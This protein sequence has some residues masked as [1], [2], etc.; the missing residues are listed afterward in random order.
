MSE[1]PFEPGH[2]Q[3][4]QGNSRPTF[5]LVTFGGPTLHAG[6]RHLALSPLRAALLGLLATAPD[7]VSTARAIRLL[8]QPAPSRRLRHRISQLIYSLNREFP[9]R[10]VVR[11]HDRQYLSA[12]IA[13]D[14]SDLLAAISDERLA[15][16]AELCKRGFLSELTRSPSDKFSGWLDETR[17]HLLGRIRKAALQQWTRLAGQGRWHQAADAARL[18]VSFNP[19]DERA[20]RM[21]IRAE[22]MSGRVGEAEAAFH[23]FVERSEMGDPEWSPN[24]ATLSLV[25]HLHHMRGQADTKPASRPVDG[26]HSVIGRPEELAALMGALL[27]RPGN[28]LRVVVLRGERGIGK[29]WLAEEAL[30]QGLVTGIRAIRSRARRDRQVSF[31]ETLLDALRSSDLDTE[32]NQLAEPWRGIVKKLLSRSPGGTESSAEPGAAAA[33][34]SNR[35]CLEAVWRLLMEVSRNKPTILFIDDFQWAD[36]D[37]VAGLQYVLERWPSLPLA[38]MLAT[39]TESLRE[40]DS[41]SE[42]LGGSLMRYEP[43]EFSVGALTR[44]A[45]GNLV[46]AVA[47]SRIEAEVRDRIVELSGQNPFFIVQL[48]RQA[49]SG[50]RLPN[51]DPDDFVPVPQSIARVFADRL[52][53]LDDDGER[54]LQLITVLGRPMGVDTLSELSGSSHDSCLQVLDRLQ[55]SRLI[56]WDSRGFVASHEL[57]LHTVYDRMNVARRAWIHGRVAAHLDGVNTSGTSAE[58]AMH[59][60]QA[61]MRA[62]ALRHAMAGA[63]VAEKAGAL[64]EAAKLFALVG[65]DTDDPQIQLG[66]AARVA[67]LH[68]LRRDTVE[69]PACLTEA[70][71]QLRNSQQP[72][73]ALVADL[74]RV[75]LLASKGSRSPR[76]AAAGIRELGRTA[77]EQRHWKAAAKAIELELHIHRREGH[78]PE[79]DRVAAHARALLERVAPE[80]RGPLHASLALHHQGDFD[81]GLGH[82]REAIAIARRTR[83]PDELLQALARLVTIQGARG[84]MADPEVT[85]AVEEGETLGGNCDD[86]LDHYNL[87]VS[88]ATGFG[89]IGRLDEARNCLAKAAPL[90][91]GVNVCEAHVALDCKMGE[92]ALEARDPDLGAAH[93]ARAR[94]LWM[95]GMGRHLGTISHSGASLAALRTGEVSMAREM[96]GD[97]PEPPVSWFEDPWVFALFKA[98]QREWRGGG[99]GADAI[100]DIAML[101]ETT[102]PAH[103]A[104]LKFE[105]A[106]LR[107]RHSLP[108]RYEVTET[109]AEAAAALGIDRRVGLLKAARQRARWRAGGG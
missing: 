22:A 74:L 88:A 101:I 97:V 69:G 105:E 55:Q 43:S 67:H 76:E 64:A 24:A 28:G 46:D 35:R 8:W 27:P 94:Q 96:A 60:H 54:A 95:P 14:Y 9:E 36:S 93:F 61:G 16:A 83:A 5:R 52:T 21:L 30:A 87:L 6:T 80:S 73:N 78:G 70:A 58:L 92:L 103:W 106:L 81:A 82:A 20:L 84:L 11:K 37:S 41:V 38:V 86:S 65:K 100:S 31:L 25:S 10:L 71:S 17:L 63:R 1:R 26:H 34:R 12:A 109:A 13:T 75:D 40:K 19:Y 57:I 91:A 42:L 59:Y 62:H 44:E 85:S 66:V 23:D 102:Q 108:Q 98:R 68:Y 53:E 90:L 39:R 99:A 45:A 29:T 3:A 7:G 33:G 79:A 72:E 89:A 18:L 107:L 49:D 4:H 48:T 51:F 15:E 50:Q 47:D 2:A 56:E 77:E 32:I 104:R